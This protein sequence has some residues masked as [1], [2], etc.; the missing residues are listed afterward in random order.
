MN[1]VMYGWNIIILREFLQHWKVTWN[2]SLDPHSLSLSLPPTRRVGLVDIEKIAPLEEGA[3][4]YN[5]AEV[6]RQVGKMKTC[7]CAWFP[8]PPLQLFSIPI[9]SLGLHVTEHMTKINNWRKWYYLHRLFI[10]RNQNISLICDFCNNSQRHR[11]NLFHISL[12]ACLWLAYLWKLSSYCL[13]TLYV[14]CLWPT[15]TEKQ[16][17]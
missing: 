3:L 6:Q 16:I 4:P 7:W 2:L 8:L 11:V 12:Y 14:Y 13:Y 5:L 9:R 17:L 10:L 1:L 15:D